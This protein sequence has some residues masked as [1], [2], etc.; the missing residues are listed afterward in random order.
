[1]EKEVIMDTITAMLIGMQ[2]GQWITIWLIWR[3]IK[4]ERRRRS[5]RKTV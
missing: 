2:I 4:S 1:M 3:A 5:R